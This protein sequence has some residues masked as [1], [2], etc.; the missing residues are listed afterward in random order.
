VVHCPAVGNDRGVVH[1][2]PVAWHRV[3]SVLVALLL[4]V[5]GVGSGPAIAASDTTPTA[6]SIA[7]P[8]DPVPG[9]YIVTLRGAGTDPAST[10]ARL[11]RTH[12]GQV[13]HVYHAA[14]DGFAVRLSE[15][16]A[17]A[18][19]SDPTVKG[20][21]QDGI[22]HATTT[23]NPAPWHLDRVD[24]RDLPL[25]NSY[26][27]DNGG[28]AV[29]AYVLDTGVR[30]TH[31]DFGGRASVGDDEIGGGVN[32]LD[33]NGHGTHVAGILG[34]TT[35]GVAKGAQLVSVRVLDCTGTGTFSSVI[36]GVDW[37]TAHAVKPAVANMS[38]SGGAFGPLDDAIDQSIASGVVYAAAA[39]NSG[40]DACGA[41]P[42]R[43]PQVLTAGATDPSDTRASFS[44]VGTC[45]SL[46]A[47]GVD[48]VSDSNASDTAQM[49]LS[50]TSMASP[51]LA[52]I[53]AGYL[54]R[55]PDAAPSEV[56]SAMVHGA[57]TG[58]VVDAGTGSPN[59]L[60]F[61][62]LA[63]RPD[64]VVA[65]GASSTEAPMDRALG[66][67]AV[68]VHALPTTSVV[69]PA[70]GHCSSVTYG[71][72]GSDVFVPPASADAGRDALRDSA[73]GTYP[74][75]V[76][77]AGHGCV[78]IARSD[79]DPRTIGTDDAAFRYFAFGIDAV[80]WASPSLDAP[81]AMT[82]TDLRRVFSCQVTDWSQ[83]PGGGTGPIRRALPPSGSGTLHNFVTRLLGQADTSSSPWV[84]PTGPGCPAPV[85][86]PTES[87][88]FELTHDPVL[89]AESQAYVV[90]YSAALWV[91]QANNSANPTL[92]VRNGVRPG[93]I[94]R[95]ATDPVAPGL[96]VGAV[97]WLGS[98]WRLN[99]ATVVGGRVVAGATADAQFDASI[100]GAPGSFTASDVGLTVQGAIVNDGTVITAVS[101]DGATATISPGATHA[102]SASIVV[103][104]PAV[105]ERNPN[106]L[107]PADGS[108]FAG[109]HYVYNVVDT[110]SPSIASARALVGFDDIPGGLTSALCRGDDQSMI[111]DAGFLDLVPAESPGGNT[112]V[113][114]RLRTP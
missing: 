46:F 24:Q 30:V 89:R 11:A 55:Y 37:V 50:G 98:S 23:Q 66:T 73:A 75:A 101:G 91:H 10:A 67:N 60:A 109:V 102:G 86:L 4:A 95:D 96:A 111:L 45:V 6:P 113:V 43:D 93:A 20:V 110:D 54:D 80:T 107:D 74:S 83:L 62:P 88:G 106:V 12:G 34:G 72:S 59:L 35:S 44:N 47:P 97:R 29:H 105:G 68:D 13:T 64:T 56:K 32:G 114:C 21:Y 77:D 19:R 36:A 38:L 8:A 26:T 84:P 69:A 16:Q 112:A 1:R 22:V 7:R 100:S 27:A 3:I 99:D 70:D 51:V 2:K 25:D 81:A 76:V 90:P 79:S 33:C 94:R 14:I 53:A 57:T 78:D 9:S 52:G 58:H 18:L 15:Q 42:G 48:V 5:L 41:S 31:T 71:P 17:D 82:L 40:V 103:G 92:D 63:P 87:T 39:G 108:V 61:T 104:S 49:V 65:V 85:I 28:A